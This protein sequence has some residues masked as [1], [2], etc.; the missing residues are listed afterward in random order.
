MAQK[1][2]WEREY[3]KPLLVS[4]G[5][6]PQKDLMKFL[7]FLRRNEGI[8]LD[9]L[10]ILDL[11]SG[12]GKNANF[13]A[14]LGN[15]VVGLEISHKAISIAKQAARELESEV[16]YR[17]F[18]IGEEYPFKNDSFDL[19]LDIM[20]S[21][22]LNEKERAIYLKEVHRV[23]RKGGYFFVRGLCKDSDKNAKALLKANPG[24]EYDTYII[25]DMGL[26]ERV[27]SKIDFINMY[28]KYFNIIK[29]DKKTNY[30]QFN[31]VKYKRNYWIA[32]MCK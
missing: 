2:V 19:V 4:L 6:K 17:V 30:A 21:N 16:D 29:L 1:E 14:S 27:F 7:R 20:T 24:L 9:G 11:G 13:L 28:S 31:G 23:L 15:H 5:K 3:N 32:Y 8:N 12:T 25:K 22:S 10:N 18:N 26:V